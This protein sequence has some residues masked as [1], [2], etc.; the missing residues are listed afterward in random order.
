MAVLDTQSS[1]TVR[2]IV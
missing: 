2:S 1:N